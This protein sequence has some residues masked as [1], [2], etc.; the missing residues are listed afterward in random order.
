MRRSVLVVGG[1][2][3][4]GDGLCGTLVPRWQGGAGTVGRGVWWHPR[5]GPMERLHLV[6]SAMAATVLGASPAGHR[7]DDRARGTLPG[8]RG[9][10]AE[11][12]ASDV[13]L[14]ASR[15]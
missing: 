14:V 2:Y 5:D 6:S 7:S 13:S 4:L 10:P 12:R 8:D 9:G 15:P 11:P 3:H 1:G